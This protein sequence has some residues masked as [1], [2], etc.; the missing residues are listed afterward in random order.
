MEQH[1]KERL[2]GA[3]VLTTLAV[4]FVPLIL[5]GSPSLEPMGGDE[6]IDSETPQELN[7][8]P[9][10]SKIVPIG[11]ATPLAAAVPAPA[12]AS[13]PSSPAT[14]PVLPKS[15]QPL[16]DTGSSSKAPAQPGAK[17]IVTP[18]PAATARTPAT[19]GWLVQLGSFSNAR[20]A[21]GLQE[22]LLANNYP[23]FTRTHKADSG[24]ITRVFVGPL[25]DKKQASELATRL[26]T[27]TRLKG[28]VF[29]ER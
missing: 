16:S 23:A 15:V 19:K 12:D 1:L 8:Q 4:I 13:G 18:A 20:N 11:T 5:S 28:R 6:G 27:E 10:N 21:A 2:V 7:L 29:R 22:R 3:V 14:T 24:E 17:P 26:F 25:A 9:F